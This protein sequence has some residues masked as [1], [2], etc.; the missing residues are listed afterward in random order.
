MAQQI[1]ATSDDRVFASCRRPDQAAQ[2]DELAA[3]YGQRARI[4]PLDVDDASSIKAARAGPSH[5]EVDALDMLIN[6][7]GIS[8]RAESRDFGQLIASAVGSVISTNAVSA[9]IVHPKR[10]A[11]C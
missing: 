5:P 11:I 1:L 8:G 9:L 10:A 3:R 4:L 2:L 7:A 6:N